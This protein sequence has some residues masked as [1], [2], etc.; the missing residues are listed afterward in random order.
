VRSGGHVLNKAAAALAAAITLSGSALAGEPGGFRPGLYFAEVGGALAASTPAVGTSLLFV[1]PALY[2]TDEDGPVGW[3]VLSLSIL[4][5]Y[6]FLMTVGTMGI[7]EKYGARSGNRGEVY[8][9]ATLASLAAVGASAAAGTIPGESGARVEE[10][11]AG[12]YIG[13]IPN[14]FLNA[15]VY[16]RVKTPATGDE[17]SSLAVTPY[18]AAYRAGRDAPTPVYGLSLSF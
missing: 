9:A 5:S 18:V 15:Y 14:A 13:V 8:W 16:N 11:V 4:A 1:I 12:M 10:A 2:G 6:P 7:G 17:T 3:E